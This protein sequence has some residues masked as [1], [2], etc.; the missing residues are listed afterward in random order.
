MFSVGFDG[1][2]A[3]VDASARRA[4]G[5]LST[6]ALA[7]R[8][9]FKAAVASAFFDQDEAALAEV[10]AIYNTHND[11]PLASVDDLKRTFGVLETF[12]LIERVIRV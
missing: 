11:K 5:R 7:E 2:A 8:G 12:T 1:G 10:L 3:L 4:Y 6:K 9:L